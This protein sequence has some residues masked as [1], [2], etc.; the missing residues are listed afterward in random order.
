MF[1]V[2]TK[3]GNQLFVANNA[4]V[5]DIGFHAVRGCV[6]RVFIVAKQA[7]MLSFRDHPSRF[8]LHPDCPNLQYTLIEGAYGVM[9]FGKSEEF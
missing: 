1:N 3:P 7:R 4:D 9:E 6:D 5:V 2:A 8:T